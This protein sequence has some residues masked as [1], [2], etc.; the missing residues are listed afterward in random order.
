MDR[1]WDTGDCWLWCE[2][3]GVPV[4]WLGPVQWMGHTAPLYACA[5]CVHHLEG[6]VRA[7]FTLKDATHE[8]ASGFKGNGTPWP[9]GWRTLT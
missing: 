6:K 1:S 3:T 8:D 4:L 9:Y 7:Y 2:R 5:P